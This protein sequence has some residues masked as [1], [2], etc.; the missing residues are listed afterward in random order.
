MVALVEDAVIYDLEARDTRTAV[1][2]ATWFHTW[3]SRQECRALAIKSAGFT[4][5]AIDAGFVTGNAILRHSI[6]ATFPVPSTKTL[7]TY[8]YC[9][10]KEHPYGVKM[11]RLGTADGANFLMPVPPLNEQRRIVET[12]KEVITNQ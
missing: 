6:S 10:A 2:K 12:L 11:P 4:S 3:R 1:K 7:G 8:R 5:S 9:Y